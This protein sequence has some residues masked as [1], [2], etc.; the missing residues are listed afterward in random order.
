MLIL[1]TG[2]LVTAADRTDPHHDPPSRLLTTE[3]QP[4]VTT[5]IVIAETAHL[6]DRELGRRVE[7][8]PYHSILDDALHVEPLI[9]AAR[10]L[11][12]GPTC[13]RRRVHAT[14]LTG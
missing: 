1:D 12:C 9:G 7:A 14:S 6:L 11:R 3:P 8:L 10:P 13:V 2:V 4:L 5:A